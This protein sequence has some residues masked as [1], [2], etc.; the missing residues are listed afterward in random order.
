MVTSLIPL[1]IK[2]LVHDKFT[3]GAEAEAITE[4]LSP[5]ERPA[6][7]PAGAVA[8]ARA[9]AA[10]AVAAPRDGRNGTANTVCSTVKGHSQQGED[11]VQPDSSSG[12]EAKPQGRTGLHHL[13]IVHS[14]AE[15]RLDASLGTGCLLY[16]SPSPRD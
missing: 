6:G 2:L 14:G 8:S 4:F 7:T 12:R 9:R 15:L 13:P 5:R 16:T 10:A 3:L 11:F 1:C